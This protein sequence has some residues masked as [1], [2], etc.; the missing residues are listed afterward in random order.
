MTGDSIASAFSNAACCSSDS[1]RPF[2]KSCMN[3]NGLEVLDIIGQGI[4]MKVSGD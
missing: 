4:Q 3:L 2:L 1:N